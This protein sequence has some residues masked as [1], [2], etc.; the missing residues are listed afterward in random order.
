[1]RELALEPIHE[2]GRRFHDNDRPILKA[3][4][5]KQPTKD[6]VMGCF[7]PKT[8]ERV[9]LLVNSTPVLDENGDIV[10]LVSSVK[11]ITGRKKM[12]T[13]NI[14]KQIN[15]Q[16]Q[17]TQASIDG[18][19][20]ERREI[21]KELHDSV[22]QQLTT[23]KLFLDIAKGSAADENTD[24]MLDNAI[25]SVANV[26]DEVRALSRS[27]VPSTLNDLG[28]VESIYELIASMNRTQALTIDFRHS[29]LRETGLKENQQ[30]TLFRIIQ[31]QLNNII[32]HAQAKH[33]VVQLSNE[34]HY[35]ILDISDDG[36]GFD[37]KTLR[38]GV[39]L[40]NMKNRAELFGG[41][42]EI[43]SE[44]GQGCRVRISLPLSNE[45]S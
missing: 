40:M 34:N 27:L 37:K 18:Q 32:K 2:D 16:K 42:F 22:G 17:L 21:G 30:L 9:W 39:G 28:L 6:L 41:S 36:R 26:I 29:G 33:A 35:L 1:M 5:T 44:P 4:Q 45:E 10:R 11:D 8:K 15:H 38:K 12:E 23:I 3:L 31:E 13:E 24:R 20:N 43:N 7:T 19:E 14:Q 25:K